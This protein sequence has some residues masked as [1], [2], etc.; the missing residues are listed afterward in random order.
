M[1]GW[2]GF[3]SIGVDVRFL[4][5]KESFF[6]P[7]GGILKKLGGIPVDRHKNNN[8]V[9]Q[10]SNLF[11]HHESLVI[12]ITP[13]G[14]RK[15]VEHWKKGFY[16]IA[17]HA[18]VPIILGYLDYKEKKGGIGPIIWPSGNYQDDWKGIEEF[19]KGKHAR[20]PEKFN[21]S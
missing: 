11:N 7:V 20:H 17:L 8:M 5:K 9:E 12:T 19:Y 1:W 14:T 6:W 18:K 4:I 21:L 15:K 13:E 3:N 10:I 16:Y 2:L